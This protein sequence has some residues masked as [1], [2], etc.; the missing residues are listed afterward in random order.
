MYFCTA[1]L[2]ILATWRSTT[3]VNSSIHARPF[4][5]ARTRARS[6][7]NRSPLLNVP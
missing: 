6:T 4:D 5:S 1:W 7:R 3:E 2:P